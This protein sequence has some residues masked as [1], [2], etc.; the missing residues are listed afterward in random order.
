MPRVYKPFPKDVS[1]QRSS[2]NIGRQDEIEE[3]YEVTLSNRLSK[4]GL[5]WLIEF[6]L[7]LRKFSR[8][9]TEYILNLVSLYEEYTNQT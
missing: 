4:E 8:E 6:L 5:I 9:D 2:F 1:I 3:E 7:S